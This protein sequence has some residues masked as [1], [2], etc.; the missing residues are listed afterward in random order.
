MR[1]VMGFLLALS[2]TAFPVSAQQRVENNGAK[3]LDQTAVSPLAPNFNGAVD[4]GHAP[5]GYY[6]TPTVPSP[7]Y[8]GEWVYYLVYAGS[9][10]M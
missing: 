6:S 10:F 1:H 8:S 4:P 2:L 7:S 9:I 5:R 3:A